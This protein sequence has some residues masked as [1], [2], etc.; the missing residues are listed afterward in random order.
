M[1]TSIHQGI[2]LQQAVTPRLLDPSSE[3]LILSPTSATININE[4]ATAQLEAKNTVTLSAICSRADA[5]LNWATTAGTLSSS[6]GTTT[7]L[8]YSTVPVVDFADI[9]VTVT[10]STDS[11]YSPSSIDKTCIINKVVPAKVTLEI[12]VYQR[13]ASAPATLPTSTTYN[14]ST[15]TLA[16]SLNGWTQSL[17]EGTDPLYVTKASVDYYNNSINYGRP[18]SSWSTPVVFSQNSTLLVLSTTG[19]AFVFDE[20]IST[21]SASPLISFSASLTNS[22]A[23]INW[24]A[25]AYNSSDVSL[26]AVTLG[27]SGSTRTLSSTQFMA[28]QGTAVRYVK[29]VVTAGSLSDYTTIYRAEDGTDSLNAF[30]TNEAH[31]VPADNLG[32]VTSFAGAST[33]LR[34]FKG[35]TEVTNLCTYS[36]VDS[37]LTSAL[38]TNTCTVSA[39]SAD[40]G[41]SDITAT[42]IEAGV[43]KTCTKRF[44][45]TKSKAGATGGTFSLNQSGGI[46]TQAVNG[47]RTPSS[48]LLST[49]TSNISSPTYLWYKDGASLGVTTS[50]YSVAES[51]FASITSAVYKCVITGTIDGTA[52]ATREDSTTI[53]KVI[54]GSNAI[55]VTASNENVTFSA[56]STGYSGIVFTTGVCDIEVYLGSAKL[57]YAASGANSFSATV[58]TTG[59]TVSTATG[60]SKYTVT[61]TGISADVAKATVTITVRNEAG[62]VTTHY[63]DLTYSVARTGTTGATG[64]AGSTGTRGTLQLYDSGTWGTGNV[65][66]SSN[67]TSK[68]ATAATANGSTPTTP[69]AG[70]TVTFYNTSTPYAYTLTYNGSTWVVPS[71]VIDG[72]LLV[73]GTIT[74]GALATGSVTSAKIAAGSITA[75]KLS[76]IALTVG[77]YI[78]SASYSAGTTGW[79][80]N[81][82][83]SSEFVNGVFRGQ[84]LASGV[85]ATSSLIQVEGYNVSSSVLANNYQTGSTASNVWKTGLVGQS[86]LSS[87]STNAGAVG[88]AGIAN[89]V[90]IGSGYGGYFSGNTAGVWS[91]G[92]IIVDVPNASTAPFVLSASAQTKVNYLNAHMLEG[93]T[94]AY[95]PRLA[96]TN[97]FTGSSNTFSAT[98][99]VSFNRTTG[100]A[101][102][103]VSSTT[104][105]T[106]LR[107]QFSS[108]LKGSAN[109]YS[110]T[111]GSVS[112]ASTATF[113]GTKPGS[114]SSNTWLQIV[115]D[116]SNFYIPIWAA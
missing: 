12:P 18:T 109:T 10:T 70:D 27:G 102:F 61:A 72:S 52:G 105:V 30:L 24:A 116:G 19:Y 92:V 13:A 42:Y 101:P 11:R 96:A 47:T 36:K 93:Y 90:G 43:T 6:T 25:T 20:A 95:F 46:F 51:A 2:L 39:M 87:G 15:Q 50:T 77:Q 7:V 71:T 33:A 85:L 73:T 66:T 110:L 98:T 111:G 108:Y 115:I 106:N 44:T 56:P 4:N 80:I 99:T 67:A 62:V 84:L 103:N 22:S 49:V 100:T 55:T 53:S 35:T 60:A 78:Q 9:E 89:S 112:G 79:R 31:T 45:V 69:I 3:V 81:A 65:P 8:T 97:D 14:T 26:G 37:G 88:V 32:T 63:K 107:A 21:T 94:S 58:S 29:V 113:T 16:G 54:D 34:V 91:K 75:D 38:S 41:T 86:V 23:T 68:V 104:E 40:T 59:V 74:S 114:A 83:G 5:V 57:N 48:I 64:S 76:A 17:P 82:D 28:G 1:A